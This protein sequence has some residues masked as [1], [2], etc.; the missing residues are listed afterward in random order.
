MSRAVHVRGCAHHG[1]VIRRQT[2]FR[3]DVAVI[4]RLAELPDQRK[5]GFVPRAFATLVIHQKLEVRA[6]PAA[7]RRRTQDLVGRPQFSDQITAI[8]MQIVVFVAIEVF[9]HK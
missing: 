5:A 8:A 4:A 7:M 9:I 3:A 1:N 6:Q 2:A